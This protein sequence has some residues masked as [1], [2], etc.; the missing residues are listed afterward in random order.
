MMKNFVKHG[1][2]TA[3]SRSQNHSNSLIKSRGTAGGGGGGGLR[4]AI[5]TGGTGRPATA[6]RGAGYTS[7]SSQNRI[8]DPLGL[9]NG[10]SAGQNSTIG[11]GSKSVFHLQDES[12]PEW[13]I[14]QLEKQIML[15]LDESVQ[16][17]AQRRQDFGQALDLAKDCVAKE[18][19]LNR[20]K[21]QSGL[22]E[23]YGPNSDLTL[24]TMF[25]L[26]ERY[27]DAQMWSEAINTYQALLKNRSFTN[28][29]RFR[30]NIGE[31]YFR[32]RQYPKAI[33][34]FRMALDQ[35]PQIQNELRLKLMANIGLAFVRLTQYADAIAAFEFI[36]A[37]RGD[38]NDAE[39]VF[40]LIVAYYALGDGD[41]MKYYFNK[42][43]Q[44]KV[45]DQFEERYGHHEILTNGDHFNNLLIEAIRNDRLRQYEKE[46]IRHVEWCILTAAKLISP[47]I[48]VDHGPTGPNG[49]MVMPIDSF[50]RIQLTN[51]ELSTTT[52]TTTITSGY[53]WCLEQIRRMASI[54]STTS[55]GFNSGL[56]FVHLADELELYKATKQ[57][58][59]RE[60]DLAIST[61]KSFESKDR[62]L[63]ASPT[64]LSFLYLLQRDYESA[65]R[66]ADEAI[67]I[68]RYCLGAV[69]NKGNI[70]YRQGDFQRA[71]EHYQEVIANNSTILEAYFNLALAE[72]KLGNYDRALDALYRLRT[73]IRIPKNR[74]NMLNQ[75]ITNTIE[76][77]LMYQIGLIY[78]SM[79]NQD[80]AR[81]FF[82]KV[83]QLVP[84][85][86]GLLIKMA[87]MASDENDRKQSLHYL[88][89]SYRYL[90]SH[91]PTIERLAAYYI[92]M[93]M[94]DQT[95]KFLE[96]L[97]IIQP[98]QIKWQ[99]MI[100]ASYRRSGNYPQALST[101]QSIHQHFPENIDCLK[102]LIRL[103]SELESNE[104]NGSYGQLVE[105]YSDRLRRLEKTRELREEQKLTSSR[106]A[107]RASTAA[108]R[109]TATA[110][111]YSN[112]NLSGGGGGSSSREGSA[113]TT[114]SNGS[115]SSGYMT[116]SITPT[117]SSPRLLI[118]TNNNNADVVN[119]G[120]SK[121]S[122]GSI[123]AIVDQ[124]VE[125]FD[126]TNME[127]PTTSWRDRNLKSS[128]GR[129]GM[130]RG[131]GDPDDEDFLLDANIDE[132]LPD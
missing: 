46:S 121:S 115:G 34:F 14:K 13:K 79:G 75:K 10:S 94:Y 24:A 54:T 81:D 73:V 16:A 105:Q 26:A 110:A 1:F 53:D 103:C 76:V 72:R 82:Q 109:Q 37:E 84:T 55:F 117:K 28:T 125:Q 15:L 69:L 5:G 41:K 95:I 47:F 44:V 92:E 35:I 29:G 58:R 17:A 91:I 74:P 107:S 59:S 52:T 33:K 129:A 86:V 31:I 108:G 20:L 119:G 27:S 2:R 48:Q 100:A 18:R 51:G 113:A 23:T 83:L 130:G 131:V 39:T 97:A 126:T 80:Q 116:K 21:E 12:T 8:F 99:L 36:L 93:K 9:A 6:V 4:T 45:E 123:S 88:L 102:F 132:M 7:Q 124:V 101:Y 60:F 67:A 32:Q 112:R 57:L 65:G 19:S 40:H 87:D 111:T 114:S 64:N 63:T 70:F 98:S 61:L 106:S 38:W 96:Q 68:D 104:P 3:F 30:M 89:E 66:Y 49:L 78:E 122:T 22:M 11:N 128:H 43:L 71:I 120:S 50:N 62:L 42:L 127:R 77:D 118:A 25:N 85:D 56:N 90:P